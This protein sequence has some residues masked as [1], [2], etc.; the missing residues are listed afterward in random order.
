MLVRSGF[1]LH[2][3]PQYYLSNSPAAQ[4][5]ADPTGIWLTQAGDAKVRVSRCRAGI[6]GIVVWLRDPI[7]PATGSLPSTTK[8]TTRRWPGDR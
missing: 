8:I 7:D 4:T 1:A 6:C 3:S 2:S 5:P